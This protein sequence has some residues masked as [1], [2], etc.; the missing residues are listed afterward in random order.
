M[1]PGLWTEMVS[2][3]NAHEVW[4]HGVHVTQDR[5]V[6]GAWSVAVAGLCARTTLTRRMLI[7]KSALQ[8]RSRK[9]PRGGRMMAKLGVGKGSRRARSATRFGVNVHDLHGNVSYKQILCMNY[10]ETNLADVRS[11]S[12]HDGGGAEGTL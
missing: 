3:P 7:R 12:R 8:P 11:G 5:L 9:T 1:I 4:R 10:T 2:D 6:R